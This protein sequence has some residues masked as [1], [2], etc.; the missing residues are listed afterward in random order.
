MFVASYLQFAEFVISLAP[1]FLHPSFS[2]SRGGVTVLNKHH[3]EGLQVRFY[4][5]T[6]FYS[7]SI[8]HILSPGKRCL[9]EV[10][11]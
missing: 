7:L 3:K 5:C 6:H 1:S 9:F 4:Y 11:D 8:T 2:I 10:L